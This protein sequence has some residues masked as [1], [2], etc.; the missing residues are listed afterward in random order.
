MEISFTNDYETIAKLNQ[1]VHDLHVEL[2]PEFFKSHDYDQMKEAFQGLMEKESNQFLL[3]TDSDVP[4]GYVWYE[5]R[6]YPE[7]IFKKGYRSLYVHQ[8]SVLKSH[9]HQ[10]CGSLLME[11]VYKNA[12]RHNCDLVELDYWVMNEGAKKFY[13]TQGFIKSREFVYKKL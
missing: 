5:I 3:L 1:T 4:V 10:G 13:E 12:C 6:N 9:Q 11:E 8:L 2:H 7:N